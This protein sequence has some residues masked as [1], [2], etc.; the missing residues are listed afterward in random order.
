MLEIA[1]GAEGLVVDVRKRVTGV[2][3]EDDADGN[4]GE[5]GIHTDE[6]KVI[7]QIAYQTNLRFEIV[8]PDL[9][10]IDGGRWEV[11]HRSDR[12]GIRGFEERSTKVGNGVLGRKRLEL[13]REGRVL[14]SSFFLFVLLEAWLFLTF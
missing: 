5:L 6:R 3:R 11:L 7:D 14:L 2:R 12:G 10:D 13:G 8:R 1:I 4:S 9:A